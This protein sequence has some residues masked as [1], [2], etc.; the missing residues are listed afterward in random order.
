MAICARP[1]PT[2]H[3]RTVWS[4]PT[5]AS[6]RTVGAEGQAVDSVGVPLTEGNFLARCEVPDPRSPILA[7]RGQALA[8]GA[9]RDVRDVAAVAAERQQGGAGSGIPDLHGLFLDRNRRRGDRWPARCNRRRRLTGPAAGRGETPT[10]WAERHASTGTRDGEL[11]FASGHVPKLELDVAADRGE[12]RAVATVGHA[13]DGPGVAFEGEDLLAGLEVPDLHVLG[14]GHHG[15]PE[16]LKTAV[17]RGE[18]LAIG[19]E[20]DAAD[21][22]DQPRRQAEEDPSARRWE[23]LCPSTKPIEK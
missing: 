16:F 11:L 5:V 13:A 9:E 14:V 8:V 1:G 6:V 20:G 23:R 4:S 7:G 22:T 2:S 3:S 15:L 19:A 18:L 17:A 10:I 12:P 21:R